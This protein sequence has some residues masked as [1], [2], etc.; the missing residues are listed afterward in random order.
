MLDFHY[1]L[2]DDALTVTDG[3][4]PIT[5]RRDQM[6]DAVWS[7]KVLPALY[8]R[9]LE[10]LRRMANPGEALVGF[11]GGAFSISGHSL[12][13]RG[14]VVD[15]YP[16]RKALEF[17]R[18]DLPAEP[19][20]R[21][22][23]RLEN[24]PSFRAR[25]DLYKFLEKS[26]LPLT[27]DG[28]FVAYRKVMRNSD[29]AL[30]DI[31]TQTMNNEPGQVVEMPRNHVNE[32][33]NTTCAEG[34]HVCAFDYLEYFGTYSAEREAVIAVKVDPADVVAI[35]TDY[36]NA[37]MRT[38]RFEVL[39]IIEEYHNNPLVDDSLFVLHPADDDGEDGDDEYGDEET[40]Y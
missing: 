3:G 32:D 24:N 1:I 29:G 9:D 20:L 37:K 23:E 5:L 22:I 34:L 15:T 13:Y 31:Y 14:Q 10:A 12:L 35:P 38:C 26:A 33:P 25:Q 8:R 6:P 18:S 2:S 21:F 11:S 36:N 40:V 39:H 30:V 17:L 7:S 19:I 4:K 28:C 16:A 27:D